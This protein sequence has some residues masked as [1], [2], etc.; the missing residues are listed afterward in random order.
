[1]ITLLSLP[2][3]R[4]K[5][6]KKKH[7]PFKFE[8][9]LPQTSKQKETYFS[10]GKILQNFEGHDHWHYRHISRVIYNFS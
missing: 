1:M 4:A 10:S 5:I 8:I 6:S 3:L 2:L 9:S 7:Q